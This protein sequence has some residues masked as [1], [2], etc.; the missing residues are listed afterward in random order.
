MEFVVEKKTTRDILKGFDKGGEIDQL[1][2]KTSDEDGRCAEV[3]KDTFTL[4][5]PKSEMHLNVK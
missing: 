3:A 1:L 5:V 2:T 4:N